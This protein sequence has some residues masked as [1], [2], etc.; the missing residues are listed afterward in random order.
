MRLAD[1]EDIQLETRRVGTV[2]AI[3]LP[4]EPKILFRVIGDN[5]EVLRQWFTLLQVKI[6]ICFY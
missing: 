1:I 4:K 5:Q 2:I 3:V 6:E